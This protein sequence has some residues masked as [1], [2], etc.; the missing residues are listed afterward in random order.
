MA[1]IRPSIVVSLLFT[2][3]GGPGI[4]LVYVPLAITRFRIPAGEPLLQTLIAAALILAGLSP[5]LD[6]IRRFIYADRGT[7]MPGVPTEHLVV[8]GALSLRAQSHVRW[9]TGRFSR[10]GCAFWNRGLVI[11]LAL[12]W[13][14]IHLFV[15]L[16]EEPTLARR[17]PG[18]YPRYKRN[19]PR[20]M[21]RL[22]PW[23]GDD[24][25]SDG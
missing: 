18:D 24:G 4:V 5:L 7:L 25:K 21:P 11:E 15:C 6:S 17:H 14:L 20:W 13:L 2:V 1:T 23:E 10:R 19:V 3:L 8:S 22:T 16:Y 12:V 9:R